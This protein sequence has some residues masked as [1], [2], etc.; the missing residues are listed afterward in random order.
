MILNKKQ[1]AATAK[2]RNLV[3]YL[4]PDSFIS[5]QFRTIRTNI[6]FITE[7]SNNKVFLLASPGTGEGKSITIAN[8]AASMAQQKE[9]ILLIDANLRSPVLHTIFKLPNTKGITNIL[10]HRVPLKEAVS[11]TE[12]GKLD[13]LTSGPVSFNPAEIIGSEL[14]QDLLKTAVKEYDMILVDAPSV[15]E[16]T[17]TR[18]LAHY[19]DGVILL[20]KRAKTE[21]EKASEALRVLELAHS[22]IIG[23]IINDK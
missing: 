11:R 8:L 14:M 2:K 23:A 10:K 3:T 18:V 19:C 4:Y 6:R 16:F 20:F 13:V 5:D 7:T 15:L 22:K 21:L 12:I 1:P 9:R 17:E